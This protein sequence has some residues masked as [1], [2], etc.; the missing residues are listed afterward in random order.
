MLRRSLILAAHLIA[1][2]TPI[3]LG[4]GPNDFCGFLDE[5]ARAS[6][7]ALM[8]FG[9]AAILILR[10]D[11]NPLRTGD[12]ATIKEA[13]TLLFLTACSIALLAF[14]SYADRHNIL[15][16]RRTGLRGELR[17]LGVALCATAG[18]VRI[19][20]LRELG[21]QFSAYVT[22]QPDHELIQT[23]IYSVVR[24]PLYL[25]LLLAGPGVAL[26]FASQLVWPILATAAIFTV[27]R[28][29]REEALLKNTF[30]SSFELY[31]ASS[32]AII[33][34]LW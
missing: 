19:L 7:L 32:R 15:T 31:R 33:P 16:I 22:L 23:G 3:F 8:A 12:P 10:I 13:Q 2:L 25:S 5:P 18:I 26:I 6:L 24:H 29:A 4:W 14:L 21:N 27:D 17:W 20:A 9:A 30:G 1:I 11:L 28:I 34:L